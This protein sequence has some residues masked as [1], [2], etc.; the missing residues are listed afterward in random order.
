MLTQ[1]QL[2]HVSR[3]WK[4]PTHQRE[5][6]VATP[7]RPDKLMTIRMLPHRASNAETELP[8]RPVLPRRAALATMPVFPRRAALATT[9]MELRVLSTP[10]Q[11]G[12]MWLAAIVH[13]V[14][15]L[16]LRVL[17]TAIQT[18]VR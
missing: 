17:L 3:A 10:I 2:R 18:G 4:A 12:V 9:R 7:A 16:A 13:S 5:L 6:S 14:P 15:R 8:P 1:T 11:T